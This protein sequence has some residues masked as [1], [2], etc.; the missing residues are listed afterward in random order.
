C[1]FFQA[2]DGIRDFHVTGVQTCAL[3][4][5][6]MLSESLIAKA[7]FYAQKQEYEAAIPYFE[8]A[9]EYNPNSILAINFLSDFYNWHVPNT[10]KYLEYALKGVRLD[11]TAQDSTATSLNYLHLSNALIQTGF[12]DE[13]FVYID[14]SLDRK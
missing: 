2:E 14:K 12:V 8:K 10:A 5:Y 1:F 9:L 11:A 13:S 3:P 7:L 6:P 4:I